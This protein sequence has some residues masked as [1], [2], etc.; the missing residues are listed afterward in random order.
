[1]V[2]NTL[3][4]DDVREMLRNAPIVRDTKE[5]INIQFEAD[6]DYIIKKENDKYKLA[7]LKWF[8]SLDLNIKGLEK[9]YHKVPE[10]WKDI[11]SEDGWIN[12]NYGFAAFSSKNNSQYEN[13]ARHLELDKNTRKAMLIYNRPS[14]HEEWYNHKTNVQKWQEASETEYAELFGD[15]MRC[16]NNQFFIRNDKLIMIVQMRSQDAMFGYNDD[17]FW[18]QYLYNRMYDRL[19]TKYKKLKRTNILMNCNSLHVHER[20]FKFL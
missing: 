15:F 2:I 13:A 6:K 14:M 4:T 10:K 5:L 1:M 17:I 3:K 12:S 11:A 18:F 7:E 19:K 9:V 16:Q 20:Y 8:I